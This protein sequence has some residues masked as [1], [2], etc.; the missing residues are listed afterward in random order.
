[1]IVDPSFLDNHRTRDLIAELDGDPC[2]PLYVLRIWA[3]CQARKAW[4]HKWKPR[5]LHSICHAPATL[6]PERLE[7]ALIEGRFIDRVGEEIVCDEWEKLNAQLIASWANGRNGG[8][9]KK[10]PT[11]GPAPLLA[12]AGEAPPGAPPE[13]PTVNPRV[14]AGLTVGQPEGEPIRLDKSIDP[15]PSAQSPHGATAPTPH[16]GAVPA[17]ATS[18][19]SPASETPPPA[20]EAAPKP[21][22]K[23]KQQAAIEIEADFAIAWPLY[24]KRPGANRA[25]ALKAYVARRK[26]GATA[27]EL[28]EGTQRYAAYCAGRAEH[29]PSWSTSFVK[30]AESFFGPSKHY[31]DDWTDPSPPPASRTTGSTWAKPSRAERS[32][33][34]YRAVQAAFAT[35]GE[36]HH[37]E[38]H[39]SRTTDECDLDRSSVIDVQARTVSH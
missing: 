26:Q 22:S 9:P 19:S 2:A 27:E 32:A 12:T 11:V 30:Q 25:N 35:L 33:D 6:T 8:R 39:V 31:L 20:P 4:R 3:E 37:G 24:P 14:S 21:R 13:N 10:A 15:P 5:S 36:H 34:R 1:M 38:N 28:L 29:D 7:A 17:A 23:A 18:A 16:G